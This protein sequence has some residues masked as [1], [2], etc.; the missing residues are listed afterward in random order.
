MQLLCA[1][2][3]ASVF[4]L[5]KSLLDAASML[6]SINVAELAFY[7]RYRLKFDSPTLAATQEPLLA[8]PKP[9]A[10]ELLHWLKVSSAAYA[11]SLGK[12][13]MLSGIPISD[14]IAAKLSSQPLR[15]GV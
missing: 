9:E 6:G 4:V 14:V 2:P 7:T 5:A 12:F 8:L 1:L 15:P 13:S 3:Q 11:K 10:V